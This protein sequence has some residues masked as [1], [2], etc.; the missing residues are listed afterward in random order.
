MNRTKRLFVLLLVEVVLLGAAAAGGIYLYQRRDQ[1]PGK[2][3]TCE[4][5]RN[6]ARTGGNRVLARS[7]L[8]E[9]A[10][11]LLKGNPGFAFERVMRSQ[12]IAQ[13]NGLGLDAAFDEL[14]ALLLQQDPSAQQHILA[15]AD[16]ILDMEVSARSAGE[17]RSPAPMPAGTQRPAEARASRPPEA[18]PRPPEPGSQPTEP[19]PPP[20]QSPAAAGPAATAAAS[21]AYQTLLD[22]KTALLAG[23]QVSQEVILKLARVRVMIDEA[24]RAD[25]AAEADG[26]LAAARR[27]DEARTRSS[28]DAALEKLRPSR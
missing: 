16:R 22:A 7:F 11:G 9:A 24:G 2:L 13:Q 21:D 6:Q 8:L 12:L 26:A 28:I 17:Q 27:R 19:P 18:G 23:G 20:R 1:T 4:K 3:A 5:E 14:N 10:I 15:L 25:V